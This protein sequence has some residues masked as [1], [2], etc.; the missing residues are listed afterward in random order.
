MQTLA[1]ALGALVLYFVAYHTYGRWLARKIFK[2]DPTN[3][4]PSVELEDGTDYV[5][6]NKSVVFGHHFTSIAGLGP[7]LGPALAVIWGWLPALL[8]VVFGSI[9]IGAVHDFGSIVISMRNRGQTVGDVAGKVLH[10][11]ARLLFLSILFLA[12]T[13]VLAVF[14]VAIAKVFKAFPMA[15]TPSLLQ[16]P[17]AM[18]IGAFIHRKG[19]N[20]LPASIAVLAIMY[21]SVWFGDS[22]ILHDFNATLASM[23]IIAWVG[24]LLLYSYAASVL[25][26]WLLLQPRDYINSLQLLSTLGLIVVGLIATPLLGRS[27]EIIAPAIETGNSS[28]LP[29]MFPF[30]FITIACGAISGFHCLVSSGTTSKQLRCETDAQFVGYGSM[31]TEGFL[32]V[33]VILACVA[34]LGLGG[35]TEIWAERYGSWA[36]AKNGALGSFILGAGNFVQTLGISAATATAIIAVFVASFAAT[37]LDTSC[38][39]QRYVIEELAG[40]LL[41]RKKVTAPHTGIRLTANP[42]SWLTNRHGATLFAVIT[43]ACVAV[44]PSPGETLT[45]ANAGK[46]GFILWPLFGAMNQLLGGLAFIVILFWLRR[47]GLPYLFALLPAIL[48]LVMPAWALGHQLFISAL[49]SDQSWLATRSW[50]LVFFAIA[51][52]TIEAWMILEAIAA[53]KNI[54][55]NK[56]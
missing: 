46:G 8:W 6:T 47:K 35:G 36:L 48:M 13:L 7:I 55:S 32:A 24:L 51:T 12:L 20:L 28:A 44:I 45:W 5:P 4:A 54:K 53:W 21:L 38:R 23:P 52:L 34:G 30:L 17:L 29:L 18:G 27:L 10:P 50:P 26:V 41:K 15:I 14:G 19:R 11:R 56:V 42:L 2:L 33:I 37:T 16:I 43:A 40:T 3:R 49:G 25:P 39:L 9:L 1:I 31:L 22:G